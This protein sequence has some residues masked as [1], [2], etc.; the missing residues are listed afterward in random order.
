MSTTSWR[1]EGG[2][3]FFT[4]KSDGTSGDEVTK[5]LRTTTSAGLLIRNSKFKPT[6][7]V[8]IDIVV[9]KGSLFS[10][11]KRKTPNIFVE[12]K[13]R[14]YVSP[15]LEVVFL[16]RSMFTDGQISKM[17]LSRITTMH[18]PIKCR[19]VSPSFMTVQVNNFYKSN[20]RWIFSSL[21]NERYIWHEDDGFAFVKPDGGTSDSTT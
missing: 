16:I 20:E 12:A 8:T 11:E 3:I 9:M 18:K 7:G 21:A 1:E 5:R 19:D 4:V 10:K 14:E 13:N 17:G 15:S 2:I 6:T